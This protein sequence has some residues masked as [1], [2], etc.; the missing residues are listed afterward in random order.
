MAYAG[1]VNLHKEQSVSDIQLPQWTSIAMW[2]DKNR[3]H[4]VI[5]IYSKIDTIIFIVMSL[6][7][8]FVESMGSLQNKKAE[9]GNTTF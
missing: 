7:R 9:N 2:V 1:L 3:I 4:F 6:M 8:R 5:S